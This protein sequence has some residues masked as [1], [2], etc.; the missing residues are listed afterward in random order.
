MRLWSGMARLYY[1]DAKLN[2][3]CFSGVATGKSFFGYRWARRRMIQ[4]IQAEGSAKRGAII[5][6][7]HKHSESQHLPEFKGALA[8]VGY[9]ENVHYRVNNTTRIL[10]FLPK[11]GI[12]Y[13]VFFVSMENW[14]VM[15][16]WQ[17]DWIWWDEPG[18][19]L[20]EL[21]EFLDQRLGRVKGGPRAQILY[22]GVVQFANWYY[23]TFG[24]NTSLQPT[25]T[26]QLPM[27]VNNYAPSYGGR[28][29]VRYREDEHTLCAHGSTF[30]NSTLPADYHHRQWESYGYKESKYRA[31][32][33]GEAI[34]VNTNVVYDTFNEGAV[35]GD[36]PID[37]MGPTPHLNLCM[38]FNQGA[39]SGV[40]LQEYAGSYYATWEN[41]R[42]CQ[43]TED[44]IKEFM[45]CFPP[46]KF[47]GR[48]IYVYGDSSGY[49]DY[50]TARTIDG[51]YSIVK[52]L[53]R[54]HYRNV[55]IKSPRYT[56]EQETRIMSTLKLHAQAAQG[57]FGL[58]AHKNCRKLIE[59]WRVTSW[60]PVK[61]KIKKGGADD[62]TH[63]AEAVD[64]CIVMKVPPV[65][66]VTSAS[67]RGA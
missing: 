17:F 42:T 48:D 46:E 32:V 44:L 59:S 15:V 10:T 7:S 40:V 41:E 26:Y 56:I 39:M 51:S 6:P 50:P 55:H 54:P 37:F 31:Q 52:A 24:A 60:D 13:Q 38:D 33:I 53:L 14:K 5:A 20:L 4:R 11:T 30:E 34:A 66:I 62:R 18:F 61:G 21:K 63:Y 36:Y 1:D 67:L 29:L 45:R 28:M 12:D 3:V 23:E 35:V 27:W 57:Y 25:A 47:G 2:H 16:G 49:N 22:T 9:H 8:E 65:N 19:G 43:I 64:Y 58:F